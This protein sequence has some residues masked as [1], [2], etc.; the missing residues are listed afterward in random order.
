MENSPQQSFCADTKPAAAGMAAEEYL[1]LLHPDRTFG[2]VTLMRL[3]RDIHCARTYRP[4]ILPFAATVWLD[5]SS[6]VTLHRFHGPRSGGR[7]AALNVLALDLDYRNTAKWRGATPEQVVLAVKTAVSNLDLPQPSIVT[8]TRRGLAVLWLIDELP[9][10]AE[11]RWRS[12]Q[13]CL[14]D[15]FSAYGADK[16]CG[17]TA[18]VF[19]IPDTVNLKNGRTVTVLD[20]TLRRYDFDR[21]SDAIYTAL[22]RPTRAMLATRKSERGEKNKKRSNGTRGLSSTARFAQVQADLITLAT[23]WG[24][25]VP[26]GLRNTWL[27]LF[28]TC[29]THQRGRVDVSVEVETA[30]ARYCTLLP[31]SEVVAVVRAG[32][33][34]Q[35][36]E[37]ERYFYSGARIAEILNVSDALAQKLRLKQ[38]YSETE[39][40]RLR[41][42]KEASRRRAK[43]MVTREKYLASHAVTRTK[44]WEY[45][46]Y[47]RA[48]WYRRGRPKP[49]TMNSTEV[50][51]QRRGISCETPPRPLQGGLPS[52]GTWQYLTANHQTLQYPLQASSGRSLTRARITPTRSDRLR[53]PREGLPDFTPNDR[54]LA[55]AEEIFPGA[56][57]GLGPLAA[58]RVL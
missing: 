9:A 40:S 15:M 49:P 48:T 44:P 22:G 39:R 26:E 32:E 47:S 7:L 36:G 54:E 55:A 46:G 53:R 35:L 11:P 13:S 21:F 41:M 12:A 34:R 19:R 24:G 8:D 58:A 4:D 18:R 33:K 1:R 27:H 52:R 29:I 5:V 42:D 10:A 20:G 50:V 37:Q 14:I 38:I 56:M 43:G 30:A 57:S 23:Y 45:F 3:D 25:Q 51:E 6:F 17:D 31:Y 16:S 28:A 2:S